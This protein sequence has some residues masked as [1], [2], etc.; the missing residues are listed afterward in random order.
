MFPDGITLALT[1]GVIVVIFAVWYGVRGLFA[2]KAD[3][4]G[5][6]VDASEQEREARKRAKTRRRLLRRGS[7]SSSPPEQRAA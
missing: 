7:K 6:E 1:A 2:P 5:I 3:F 4:S